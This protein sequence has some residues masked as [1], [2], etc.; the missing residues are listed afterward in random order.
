MTPHD[1]DD[2]TVTGVHTVFAPVDLSPEPESEP[3]ST[4]LS[5]KLSVDDA[6][7]ALLPHLFDP[8]AYQRLEESLSKVLIQQKLLDERVRRLESAQ[9][10]H[11]SLPAL[12]DL[13]L[14]RSPE[15]RQAIE[16]AACKLNEAVISSES[17]MNT[18]MVIA[19][20]L[21]DAFDLGRGVRLVR[22]YR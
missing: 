22:D 6:P 9:Q 17:D 18:L 2:T 7:E 16:K 8:T 14:G 19:K 12:S 15:I 3:K 21:L 20:A 13:F 11:D 5:V 1:D 10:M 4:D